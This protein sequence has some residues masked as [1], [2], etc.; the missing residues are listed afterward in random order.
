MVP[1]RLICSPADVQSCMAMSGCRSRVAQLRGDVQLAR[2]R[3]SATRNPGMA[4]R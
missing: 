3:A 1:D 2:R 4:D